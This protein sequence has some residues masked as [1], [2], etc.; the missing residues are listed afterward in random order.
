M[1]RLLIFLYQIP[2]LL[3]ITNCSNQIG[4]V[5]ENKV[6]LLVEDL[7]CI[8]CKDTGYTQGVAAVD[9]NND[10]FPEIYATNSWTNQNN[11]FY[12][13]QKGIFQKDTSLLF[14]KSELNSNGCSWGDLTNDGKYDLLIANVNNAPNQLFL[15]KDKGSFNKLELLQNDSSSSWTYGASWVDANNS[16]FLDLYLVNYKEQANVFYVNN[17]GK[18]VEQKNNVLSCENHSSFN[19]IWTDLNNDGLQD[20]V[21]CGVGQNHIFKNLGNYKFEE[22]VNESITDSKVLSYGCSPADFNND[23]MMDL[24]FTNWKKENHLYQNLGNWKFKR[25]KSINFENDCLLSEGSCWGDYDNDSWIDLVVSNDGNN[26]LYR[27]INGIEFKKIEVDSFTNAKRNSN[28]IVWFD[29]DSDGF[30]D[31]YIASGGNQNNQFFRNIGNNNNWIKIKLF[32]TVSNKLA[33]GSKVK[34]YSNDGFQLQEVSSQSGGG[35]GSQKPL[36]LHFGLGK[37]DK[38]DSIQIIWNT[39]FIKTIKDVSINKLLK[40]IEE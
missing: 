4:D 2:F 19:A 14:T 8:L 3:I 28:G 31:L 36:S 37:S 13:N 29:A 24:F 32:G 34:V 26:E 9:I 5:Q 20:V 21:I 16:G 10:G 30:L 7:E 11:L 40:I 39:G 6:N 17:N 38:V 25:I 35:C 18:L 1:K 27:N 12:W 33:I 22:L 15:Y 23:G